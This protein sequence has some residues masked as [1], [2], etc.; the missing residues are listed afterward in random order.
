MGAVMACSKVSV[1]DALREVTILLDE[2]VTSYRNRGHSRAVATDDAAKAL[3][4]T[5]RRAKALLY[6]ESFKVTD[7]E[8][9][10]IKL[11]YLAHLDDE[12]AHF[13]AMLDAAKTKRRM[14]EMELA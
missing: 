1:I 4:V 8:H 3:G 9:R 5:P 2:A 6:G 12:A 7:E 13:S 14:M 10:A 11:A